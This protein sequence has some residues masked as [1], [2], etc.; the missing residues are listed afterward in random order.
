MCKIVEN[1]ERDDKGKVTRGKGAPPRFAA[2]GMIVPKSSHGH[3]DGIRFAG[4]SNCLAPDGNA[5]KHFRQR[6]RWVTFLYTAKSHPA[7]VTYGRSLLP[8][9]TL[10]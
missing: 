10:L 7:G 4:L 5:V 3:L 2:V 9:V 1:F 8:R 6:N